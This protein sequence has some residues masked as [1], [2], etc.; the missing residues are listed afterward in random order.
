MSR[1]FDALRAASGSNGRS[2][3]GVES[4]LPVRRSNEPEAGAYVRAQ[5]PLTE[6]P[7]LG[8]ADHPEWDA[9]FDKFQIPEPAVEPPVDGRDL[10]SSEEGA[11]GTQVEMGGATASTAV[12]EKPEAATAPGRLRLDVKAGLVPNSTDAGVMEYYRRLRTKILQAQEGKSFRTLVVASSSPQE[13]KTVTAMN[14][15]LSF[16]MLDSFKVLVVDGDLRRGTLGKWIGAEEQPG[17]SDLI[18]GT[19]SLDQVLIRSEEPPVCF[20]TRGQS[21]V[22]PG[23]LLNSPYLGRHFRRMSEGFDLVLIDSPPLNML[24]DTQLLVRSC[25]AVLLVARAFSTT[26]KAL[27]Q[28]VQELGQARVIGTVLNGGTKAHLYRRYGYY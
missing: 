17:F 10:R 7:A 28:A 11:S 26:R 27:E 13:G 6:K 15:A 2:A 25:D 18:E 21:K 23:E 4:S 9:L 3:E 16:A 19:T 1:F 8:S 14:L 22:A 5:D 12:A 24:T 20:M